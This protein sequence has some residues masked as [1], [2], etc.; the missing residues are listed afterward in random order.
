[1]HK[2]RTNNARLNLIFINGAYMCFE[3]SNTSIK[4]RV[5]HEEGVFKGAFIRISIAENM[6][7]SVTW[8]NDF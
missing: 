5:S 1:M 3:A 6:S 4:L 2:A 8:E 7:T